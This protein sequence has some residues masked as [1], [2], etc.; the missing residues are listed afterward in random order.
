MHSLWEESRLLGLCRK[1][2]L[3]IMK[4]SFSS[5]TRNISRADLDITSEMSIEFF[6]MPNDPEQ[7][8]ATKENRDYIYSHLRKFLNIIRFGN[9]IIGYS[10]MIPCSNNIADLF[11]KKRI[12]ENDLFNRVK[13][14]RID[15]TNFEAIYL[16]S[17]IIRPEHRR[18]GLA[19]EGFVKLIKPL[20]EKRNFKSRFFFWGYTPAGRAA[21]LKLAR[22]LNV[23]IEERKD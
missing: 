14:E 16:C 23:C 8:Q 22:V 15:D 9:E 13:E 11:I 6:G 5:D 10:F 21:V 20:M 17:S 7:F 4:Y 19:L 18:K 12:S 3:R 2:L 1:E